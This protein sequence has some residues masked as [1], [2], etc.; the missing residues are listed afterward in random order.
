[1]AKLTYF[2]ADDHLHHFYNIHDFY[3]LYDLHNGT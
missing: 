1:M 3:Y 2:V